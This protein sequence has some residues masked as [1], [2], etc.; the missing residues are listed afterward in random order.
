MLEEKAVSQI[1]PGM[2]VRV[3]Q[4]IVE[5]NAKGE[6]KKRIQVFEGMVLAQRHGREAGATI[7]VRK[8][9]EGIGVEKIF[10][11]ASPWIEKI[12]VIKR[13]KVRRAKLYYLRGHKKSLKERTA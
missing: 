9:S 2:T 5:K 8:V 10:P 6:D 3:H 1:R 12:D 13:A 4:V 7:T 11:L